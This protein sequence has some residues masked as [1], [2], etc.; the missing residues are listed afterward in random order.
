MKNESLFSV[1]ISLLGRYSIEVFGSLIDDD[2]AAGSNR[3]PST[4]SKTLFTSVKIMLVILAILLFVGAE[5][6]KVVFRTNFGSKSINPYKLV[7]CAA[8][9]LAMGL[10]SISVIYENEFLISNF[11]LFSFIATGIFYIFLSLF[12]LIK[13][14]RQK[15]NAERSSDFSEYEGNSYILSFLADEGWPQKKIK[16]LAEPLLCIAVGFFFSPIN[17]FLGIPIIFCGLSVWLYQVIENIWGLNPV[18]N[19]L[20]QKGYSEDPAGSFSEVSF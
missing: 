11:G 20:E 6:V 15:K 19:T 5:A 8:C 1:L 4:S 16:T 17:P 3:T 7:L 12:I 18:K 2:N 9:F 14:F 13:G 10:F